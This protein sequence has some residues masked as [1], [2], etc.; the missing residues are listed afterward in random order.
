MA[1]YLVTLSRTEHTTMLVS[2]DTR[3]DAIIKALRGGGET[4]DSFK[5]VWHWDGTAEEVD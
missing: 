2:A 4:N 3:N 1:N 5:G